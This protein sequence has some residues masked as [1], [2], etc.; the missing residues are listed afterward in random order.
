MKDWQSFWWGWIGGSA[1][2]GMLTLLFT[3][4]LHG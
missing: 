3:A 4:A 2:T 1:C